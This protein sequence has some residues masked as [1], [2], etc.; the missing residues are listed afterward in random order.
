MLFCAEIKTSNSLC[1]GGPS[2][3]T[4]LGLADDI[5]QQ[6]FPHN[7]IWKWN[8]GMGPRGFW[9]SGFKVGKNSPL[10]KKIAGKI[11]GKNKNN[12]FGHDFFLLLKLKM[13][14]FVQESAAKFTLF[15]FCKNSFS[16]IL[17]FGLIFSPIWPYAILC[18][19]AIHCSLAILCAPT[20]CSVLDSCYPVS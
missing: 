18:A 20:V 8:V 14:Y 11:S 6:I 2:L 5:F 19:C 10:A 16:K 9:E 4:K 12:F 1:T 3:G 15:I 7:T 13:Q 17:F